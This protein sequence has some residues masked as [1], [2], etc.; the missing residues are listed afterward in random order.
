[1]CLTL[2]PFGECGLGTCVNG[3]CVCS[4]GITQNLEFFYDEIPIT[5]VTFCDYS[6]SAMTTLAS[7]ILVLTLFYLLYQVRV[8]ETFTQVC[9][10]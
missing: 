5:S 9:R 1:M 7:V 3:S 4:E 8:L 6:E 10:E 2:P